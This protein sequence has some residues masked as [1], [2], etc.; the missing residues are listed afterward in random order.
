VRP[1]R[2]SNLLGLAVLAGV[3]GWALAATRYESLALPTYAPITA[4]LMAV[5]ELG[6]ARVV[7]QK[8]RGVGGGRPMHPL[9]VARAVV[10]AKASSAGGAL[11]VG[12][13]GGYML[14]V[15]QRTDELR[16]ASHDAVIAGLS[17]GASL[18]LVVAALLVERAC[19]TPELPD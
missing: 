8:V 6:L 11:L 17:A 4:G 19:R 15:V 9:Q 5:F 13:Y 1:T 14:W 16:S 7:S 10:L 3:L 2:W 18:L 12:F